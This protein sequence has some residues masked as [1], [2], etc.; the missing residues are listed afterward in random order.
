MKYPVFLEKDADSEY[1]VTVP[2]LPGCFSAGATIE[3]AFDN[4]R[5]AILT[6]IEGLLLD[7]E[8]VPRASSIDMLK[9]CYADAILWGLVEVDISTLS[10]DV[11]RINVT[12]P[13]HILS[14]I[15]AYAKHEGESRSGFL[16]SAA[17][18]YIAS[19]AR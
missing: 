1:G 9:S 3:D 18:E 8:L 19:R 11:R 10:R 17:M 5:E 14:K 12:I 15:D 13:E 2:D 7:D 16:A 4:A 6:H